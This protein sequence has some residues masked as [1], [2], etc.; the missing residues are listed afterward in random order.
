MM[1]DEIQQ[2]EDAAKREDMWRILQLAEIAARAERLGISR[3]DRLTSVLDIEL[4]DKHWHLRLNDWMNADDFNFAHDFVG[5]QNHID[6]ETKSFD[7]RFVP[8]FAAN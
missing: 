5:I 1:D 7:N 6:R 8:R 2:T 4:A 3:T